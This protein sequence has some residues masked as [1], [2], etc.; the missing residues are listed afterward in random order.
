MESEN[1]VKTDKREESENKLSIPVS[2][3][4]DMLL[5]SLVKIRFHGRITQVYLSV[6]T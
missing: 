1:I 5:N 4:E 3:R 6:W 2:T